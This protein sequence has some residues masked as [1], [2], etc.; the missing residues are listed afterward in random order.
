MIK[1]LFVIK[2][3]TRDSLT[4]ANGRVRKE[5]LI[6]KS[7]L[8]NQT[9]CDRSFAKSLTLT[10]PSKKYPPIYPNSSTSTLNFSIKKHLLQKKTTTNL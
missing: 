4:L 2:I 6:K 3:L 5:D 7:M 1:Y 10:N 8:R 9:N